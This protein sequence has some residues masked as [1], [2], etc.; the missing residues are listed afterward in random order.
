MALLAS[1]FGAFAGGGLLYLTGLLGQLL[2]RKESMWLWDVKL[3]AMLGAFIGSP[4]VFFVFLIAP[5]LAL[6]LA[7]FER[8]IRKQ[9]TI[10]FG[11]YLAL[12]GAAVYLWG[13][14]LQSYFFGY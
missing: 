9:E 5:I 11:P 6:P 13:R 4:G 14:P 8:F 10:P 1:G 2:F 12:A 7:L 3:L